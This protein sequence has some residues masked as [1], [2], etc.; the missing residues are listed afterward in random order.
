MIATVVLG[1]HVPLPFHFA[2]LALCHVAVLLY[3]FDLELPTVQW[4]A[5][6]ATYSFL[7]LLVMELT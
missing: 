3:A 5:A 7:A 6:G 4:R 2:A 1:M